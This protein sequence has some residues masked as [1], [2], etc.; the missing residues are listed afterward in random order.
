VLLSEYSLLCKFSGEEIIVRYVCSFPVLLIALFII[1]GSNQSGFCG[2]IIQPAKAVPVDVEYLDTEEIREN[3]RPPVSG[4]HIEIIDLLYDNDR[5]KLDV[6][7][8]VETSAGDSLKDKITLSDFNDKKFYWLSPETDS[9]VT[10]EDYI[11][12]EHI[13]DGKLPI[14]KSIIYVNGVSVN[15]T[16]GYHERVE[17]RPGLYSNR[18][19]YEAYL[20]TQENYIYGGIF[21]NDIDSY[22]SY[23]F[24]KRYIAV[25]DLTGKNLL[26]Y[27]VYEWFFELGPRPFVR[28]RDLAEYG[29]SPAEQFLVVRSYD[30]KDTFNNS[31][32]FYTDAHVIRIATNEEL[33][34][35][36]D[37]A[38]TPDDRYFVTER[39]GIP[40]LVNAVTDEN[41]FHYHLPDEVEMVSAVISPDTKTVVIAGI[42]NTLY[43]FP[44]G[45]GTSVENWQLF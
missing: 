22:D 15:T 30:K 7:V 14:D 33:E 25:W 31:I 39:E 2:T 24:D 44:S 34:A 42:D 32:V 1:A 27:V 38:F 9:T 16:F 45:L 10:S 20:S 41:L 23:Y 36:K 11:F 37:V 3:H 28:E 12:I 19:I 43:F 6:R 18:I 8:V 21:E 29:I 13:W 40:T 26:N 35:G 17:Y 5:L 4:I